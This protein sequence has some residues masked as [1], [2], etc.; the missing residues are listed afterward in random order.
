MNCFPLAALVLQRTFSNLG[1]CGPQVCKHPCVQEAF[2][3][4]DNKALAKCVHC[5]CAV[6]H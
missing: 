2:D 6:S 5:V 4:I 3:C 1:M